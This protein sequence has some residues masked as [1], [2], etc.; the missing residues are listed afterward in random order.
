M[1]ADP[2]AM[3]DRLRDALLTMTLG[4]EMHPTDC[5]AMARTLDRVFTGVRPTFDHAKQRSATDPVWRRALAGSLERHAEQARQLEQRM[6][7]A[8]AGCRDD[9]AVADV[10]A[11]MPTL[12]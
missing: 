4:A 12:Q 11:T 1:P 6:V 5:A 9:P 2:D 10:M 3:A 8:L 7:A